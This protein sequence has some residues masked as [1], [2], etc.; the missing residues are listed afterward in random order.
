[1]YQK[2]PICNG[3]SLVSIPPNTAGD[4]ETFSSASCGPWP[5]RVCDGL[6]ILKIEEEAEY[7]KL[8]AQ[9]K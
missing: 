8:V 3:T 9:G 1:M 2:C 6:G 7:W 5:C 4:V